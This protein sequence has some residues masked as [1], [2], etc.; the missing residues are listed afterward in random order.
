MN[1]FGKEETNRKA[2]PWYDSSEDFDYRY[3]MIKKTGKPWRI[4]AGQRW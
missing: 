4:Y 3:D 2:L 1:L